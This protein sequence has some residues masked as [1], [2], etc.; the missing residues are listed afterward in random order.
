MMIERLDRPILHALKTRHSRFA[1]N[2]GLA[3]RYDPEVA[4]FAAAEND[5]PDA[6]AA[7]AALIPADRT[8]I[9]LQAERT[10][11]PAGTVAEMVAE[12]VQ[13]LAEAMPEPGDDFVALGEAD[14]GDMLALAT[15]TRPGPF[16]R[17]TPELGRFIGVRVDGRLAAMAGERLSLPGFTEVSGVCTHPDFRGRG[18][19]GMLSRAVARRILDRGDVPFLHAW[20]SN[21]PAIRLYEALGFR[22]RRKM[23]MTVLRRGT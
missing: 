19:G 5:T 12:G 22:L 13:M 8:V 1:T 6:M 4:S 9:L 11:V 14:A 18:Y 23:A 21:T 20:A 7:L 2:A 15:L 17:R 3:F 10:P 16:L